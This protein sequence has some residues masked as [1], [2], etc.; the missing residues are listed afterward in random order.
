MRAHVVLGLA[1]LSAAPP[2]APG[3]EPAES[4]FRSSCGSWHSPKDYQH[5]RATGR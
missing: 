1:A 2:S 3:G 4:P 5:F